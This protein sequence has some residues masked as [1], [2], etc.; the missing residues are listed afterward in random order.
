MAFYYAVFY[1]HRNRIAECSILSKQ[2]KNQATN[3]TM[4]GNF[5]HRFGQDF[6][7]Q[8]QQD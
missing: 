8:T 2:E 3:K 6:S 1:T 5:W 4:L 7:D